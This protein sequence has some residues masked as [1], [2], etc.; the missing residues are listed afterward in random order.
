MVIDLD[1][2]I[3]CN[4]CTMA[5][6]AEH[7]T[8]PGV[9]WSKVLERESGRTPHVERIFLP[10]L[11]NHCENPP[12]LQVCPTL[13]TYQDGDGIVQ[14][15]YEKCIGCRA[16]MAA[17]PYQSRAYVRKEDH[18]FPD[19]AIPHGV[20]ELRGHEGVVQKCTLCH[21]RVRRGEDPACV[22]VCPTSCRT[23][24]D[25][26]DPEGPLAPLLASERRFELLPEIGTRPR[27]HYLL[28][29]RARRLGNRPRES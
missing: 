26:D 11:C 7:G 9:F 23:F 24:G 3:G 5:C 25:P 12:C 4:A 19:T 1:L 17:C 8:G 22:E 16:C 6:K 20:D 14:I 27:V 13:A 2:C 10:V 29:D 21:E 28:S 18:Y 15:D